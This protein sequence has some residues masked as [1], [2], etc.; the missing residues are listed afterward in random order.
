M[1]LVVAPGRVV[2]VVEEDVLLVDDEVLELVDDDVL[3]RDVDVVEREVDVV[4][5][6]G[7]RRQSSWLAT[8]ARVV[9]VVDDVEEVLLV[10]DV[11]LLEELLDELLEEVLEEVTE[12][13][14]VDVGQTVVLVLDERIG[15]PGGNSCSQASPS[16]SPSR[17]SWSPGCSSRCCSSSARVWKSWQLKPS[18]AW[19]A[20][21][22]PGRET[23]VTRT[24]VVRMTRSRQVESERDFSGSPTRAMAQPLSQERAGW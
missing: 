1:V 18:P 15:T 19:S 20:R 16:L 6:Q 14:V 8:K 24:A 21:A 10:D 3:D 11:L 5:G 23:R 2:L 13:L 4:L 12:D 17:L 9:L 22:G 7:G